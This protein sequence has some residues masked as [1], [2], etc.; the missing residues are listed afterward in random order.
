MHVR[1]HTSLSVEGATFM[2]CGADGTGYME[3][4]EETGCLQN[5]LLF[6]E[7][8]HNVN[9]FFCMVIFPLLQGNLTVRGLFQL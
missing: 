6:R 5:K 8:I 2:V 1:A 9:G 4:L 7:N 3:E